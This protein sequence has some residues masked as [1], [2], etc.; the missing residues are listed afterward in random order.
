MSNDGIGKGPFDEV[1]CHHVNLD[2][3]YTYSDFNNKN[4]FNVIHLNVQNIRAKHSQVIEMLNNLTGK[5]VNVY[6]SLLCETFM[7]RLNINERDISGYNKDVNFRQNKGGGGIAVYVHTDLQHTLRPHLTINCNDIFESCFVEL[8]MNK[9]LIIVGGIY[10]APNSNEQTFL[11]EYNSI[12][13]I[14]NRE[15]KRVIVGTDRNLDYLKL[16]VHTMTI[17]Y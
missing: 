6:A 4:N 11:H 5:G 15:R 10:C 13:N 3:A 8:K 17:Y 12:L 14:I 16:H 2:S 1:I 9:T 7:D